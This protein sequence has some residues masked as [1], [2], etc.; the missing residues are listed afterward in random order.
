[1]GGNPIERQINSMFDKMIEPIKKPIDQ[2][3]KQIKDIFDSIA[4]AFKQIADI[5]ELIECPTRLFTNIEKCGVFFS[6]DVV[7]IIV[8]LLIKWIPVFLLIY[9][10]LTPVAIALNYIMMTE[11]FTFELDDICPGKDTLCF[12]VEFFYYSMGNKK[13]ILN[14]SSDDL[15]K[16]YCIYP[17]RAFFDPYTSFHLNEMESEEQAK[18]VFIIALC[19]LICVI[20]PQLNSK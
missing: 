1:M 12:I 2:M 9:I 6:Y 13:Y 19:I 11:M 5:N 10:P 14:R 3:I 15:H 4:Y 18:T 17:I 8:H 16:C 20:A 7:M